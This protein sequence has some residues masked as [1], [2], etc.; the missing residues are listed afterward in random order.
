MWK[1]NIKVVLANNMVKGSNSNAN[2]GDEVNHNNVG[3]HL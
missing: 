1:Y 3:M 2:A